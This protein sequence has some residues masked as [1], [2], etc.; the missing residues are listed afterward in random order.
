MSKILMT[1]MKLVSETSDDLKQMTRV[2]APQKQVTAYVA[3]MW[4]IMNSESSGT[5]SRIQ[6]D[7]LLDPEYEGPTPLRNVS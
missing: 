7:E 5:L 1:E 3:Q 6:T 2:P 4:S